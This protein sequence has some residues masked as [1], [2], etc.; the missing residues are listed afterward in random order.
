MRGIVFKEADGTVCL[1]SF[2]P[3][4]QSATEKP[5]SDDDRIYEKMADYLGEIVEVEEYE[6]TGSAELKSV[7]CFSF[8]DNSNNGQPCPAR[9][10]LR[11]MAAADCKRLY[12]VVSEA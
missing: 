8:C 6:T 3:D 9:Q 12:Q 10:A 1:M 2:T 4:G 11:D 5:I 7:C